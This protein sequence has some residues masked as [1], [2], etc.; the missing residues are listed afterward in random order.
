MHAH[1]PA[2]HRTC[3]CACGTCVRAAPFRAAGRP[4]PSPLPSSALAITA[5]PCSCVYT[6][7][8]LLRL[9]LVP[10][11]LPACTRGAAAAGGVARRWAAAA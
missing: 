6:Y 8:G 10:A 9:L 5:A 4:L 11:C 2:M 7:I 1:C 3:V